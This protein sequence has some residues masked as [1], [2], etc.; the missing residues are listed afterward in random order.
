MR[1]RKVRDSSFSP[2]SLLRGAREIKIRRRASFGGSRRGKLDKDV[3][4]CLLSRRLRKDFPL[5]VS[6]AKK[7][8]RGTDGMIL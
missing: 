7:V 8:E 4:W 3:I 1:R 5:K 2:S 6:I